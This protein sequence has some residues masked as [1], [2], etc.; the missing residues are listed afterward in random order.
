MLLRALFE[1][2]EEG[3]ESDDE[4]E[5]IDDDELN[6]MIARTDDEL[7]LFKKIDKERERETPYGKGKKLPR[8]IAEEELPLI[9]QEKS[10]LLRKAKEHEEVFMGRGARD[11]GEVVYTDGLTDDQWVQVFP[12][13]NITNCRRSTTK[14]T[15]KNLLV[16]S[17]NER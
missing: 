11:R 3:G 9:Y 10:D 4:N 14:K 1:T 12:S 2:R 6:E 8:L 13:L 5:E 7:V 16:Q 15:S 17:V